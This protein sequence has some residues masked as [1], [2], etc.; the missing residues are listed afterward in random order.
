M[1]TI[2]TADDLIEVLRSD[3]RVRS[4][5]RRE[6]LT[7]EVV[8]LPDKVDKMVEAQT[9]M[10]E[11]LTAMQQTQDSMLK[12]QTAILKDIKG[13]RKEQKSLRKEQTSLRK[14]HKADRVESIQDMHRFRGNYAASAAVKRRKRIAGPFA[15]LWQMRQVK[16]QVLSADDVDALADGKFDDLTKLGFT[17][18]DVNLVSEADLVIGVQGRRGAKPEFY[19]VVEAAYTGDESD[20]ERAIVRARIVAAATGLATYAVVASVHLHPAATNRVTEDA[21]K[22]RVSDGATSAFWYKIVERDM[23]PASPR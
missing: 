23:E 22:S 14:E 7:D 13:I 20:V 18:E 12:T 16:C 2:N 10:Q 8:A 15:R 5:V 11:S 3:D 21:S 19:V 17:D 4:A 6:L 1:A 9:A